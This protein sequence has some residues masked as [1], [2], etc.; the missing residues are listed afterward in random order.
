MCQVTGSSLDRLTIRSRERALDDCDIKIIDNW[1]QVEE[2]YPHA[3]EGHPGLTKI[4][5]TQH[6]ELTLALWMTARIKDMAK[7]HTK[8][9]EIGV[10]K[11]CC[12]WCVGY[13]GLLDGLASYD[14]VVHAT[15]GKQPTGW[16]MPPK[17]PKWVTNIMAEQIERQLD[18]V[19]NRCQSSRR[20]DSVPEDEEDVTV[21]HTEM[22]HVAQ[23]EMEQM[24]ADRM[25]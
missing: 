13:L 17:G 25:G 12:Q 1:R 21:G 10:S 15:H 11:S 5:F 4:K 14:I 7:P 2:H 23:A 22:S 16:L 3:Q 6:C 20:S 24:F 19:I 8:R 18:E 9:I